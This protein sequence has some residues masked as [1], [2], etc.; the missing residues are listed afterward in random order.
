MRLTIVVVLPEP[1]FPNASIRSGSEGKTSLSDCGNENSGPSIGRISI[2]SSKGSPACNV[3]LQHHDSTA[4]SRSLSGCCDDVSQSQ[5]KPSRS[6]QQV[7]CISAWSQRC[8]IVRRSCPNDTP[9]YLGV[10]DGRL[11]LKFKN[12]IA[13]RDDVSL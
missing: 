4:T 7:E 9:I 3:T 13:V 11:V 2:Y 8:A 5:V 6:V 12:C 10:H 1:E